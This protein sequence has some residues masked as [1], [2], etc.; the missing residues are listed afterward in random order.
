[1]VFSG[2]ALT[3]V[4]RKRWEGVLKIGIELW[5]RRPDKSLCIGRLYPYVDII[6]ALLILHVCI[7][8][9]RYLGKGMWEEAGWTLGERYMTRQF[10]GISA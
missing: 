10:V 1:M 8:A 9:C 6:I 3:V 7:Y 2:G 4:V 5:R